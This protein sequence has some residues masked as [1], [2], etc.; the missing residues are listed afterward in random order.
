M[1]PIRESGE[2]TAAP[3]RPSAPWA[4]SGPARSFP[5][6]GGRC[7]ARRARGPTRLSLPCPGQPGAP[8]PAARGYCAPRLAPG[9]VPAAR[10]GRKPRET[11]ANSGDSLGAV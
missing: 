4:R 11:S 5:E 1:R 6:L 3:T 8:R 2:A 10:R 7:P 9:E